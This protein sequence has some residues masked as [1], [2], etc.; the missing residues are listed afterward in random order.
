MGEAFKLVIVSLSISFAIILVRRDTV[1]SDNGTISISSV[2]L[3]LLRSNP[4]SLITVMVSI[5][6]SLIVVPELKDNPAEILYI[7]NCR[8]P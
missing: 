2:R 1:C 8:V 3:V 6:I 7:C 4:L 5:R